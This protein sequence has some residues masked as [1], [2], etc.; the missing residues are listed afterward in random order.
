VQWVWL[1]LGCSWLTAGESCDLLEPAHAMHAC[2]SSIG[3]NWTKR[4]QT[5]TVVLS[6][7]QDPHSTVLLQIARQQLWVCVFLFVCCVAG[8]PCAVYLPAG[9]AAQTAARCCCLLA[10]QHSMRWGC[11]QWAC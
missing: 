9:H 11:S 1:C 2:C 3:I 8:E 4:L 7:C 10:W 6:G 5:C